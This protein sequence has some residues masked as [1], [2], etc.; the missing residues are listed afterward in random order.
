MSTKNTNTEI[1]AVQATASDPITKALTDLFA[2][3][4]QRGITA[5]KQV[6]SVLTL[7]SLKPSEI[8]DLSRDD[9]RERLKGL[10]YAN[11]LAELTAVN[12]ARMLEP[13]INDIIDTGSTFLDNN[14]CIK[15]LSDL[16]KHYGLA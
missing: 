3:D 4:E 15:S 2:K 7:N 10:Y 1:Q 5:T 9:R 13:F 14:T 16:A 6:Y 11:T 8:K 12:T